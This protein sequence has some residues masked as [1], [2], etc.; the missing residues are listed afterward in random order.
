ML[1]TFS[2]KSLSQPSFS[3]KLDAKLVNDQA[4]EVRLRDVSVAPA[5]PG[6]AELLRPATLPHTTE[7]S[8]AV[9]NRWIFGKMT[10]DVLV[11]RCSPRHPRIVDKNMYLALLGFDFVHELVAAS[12]V[13]YMSCKP[14]TSQN[15]QNQRSLH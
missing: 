6:Y 2:A 3:G 14:E 8:H 9:E 11:Y 5:M 13:L 10:L 15:G 12:F 7:L 4:S 1:L